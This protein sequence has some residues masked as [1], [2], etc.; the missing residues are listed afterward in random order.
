MAATVTDLT[1]T[2]LP[3]FVFLFFLPNPSQSFSSGKSCCSEW[4]FVL[5]HVGVWT[6]LFGCVCVCARERASR[7]DGEEKCTWIND[8]LE[9]VHKWE[10][11]TV[12]LQG[13]CHI[14]LQTRSMTW[15]LWLPFVPL[16]LHKTQYT[17]THTHTITHIYTRAW[18]YSWYHTG[19]ST[20][21]TW[22]Y[23]SCF[24]AVSWILTWGGSSPLCPARVQVPWRWLR[25]TNEY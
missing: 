15:M 1:L 19:S 23:V 10:G 7:D 13:Q 16:C 5:T 6:R 20:L 11:P 25:A 21:T 9:Q 3:F 4:Q 17:Q 12:C 2:C 8:V 22:A 24:S 14:D 18:V